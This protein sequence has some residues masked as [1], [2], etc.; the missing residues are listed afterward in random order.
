MFFPISI[1]FSMLKETFP[2]LGENSFVF[3]S[4]FILWVYNMYE[5]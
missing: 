4:S 5:I 1:Y 3:S 2:I